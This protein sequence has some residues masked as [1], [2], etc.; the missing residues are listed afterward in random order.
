VSPEQAGLSLGV[1]TQQHAAGYDAVNDLRTLAETLATASKSVEITVPV[2]AKS[3]FSGKLIQVKHD[4]RITLITAFGTS[5]PYVEQAVQVVSMST[6][7]ATNRYARQMQ[8]PPLPKNW[9][10]ITATRASFP[11]S[12]VPVAQVGV[13]DGPSSTNALPG[14][15]AGEEALS[16]VELLGAIRHTRDACGQ[17]RMYLRQGHHSDDL[18]PEELYQLFQAIESGTE[19]L[20]VA[21][22]LAVGMTSATCVKVARAIAGTKDACKREVAELLLTAG[23]VPDKAENARLVQNELSAEQW[24]V[25]EKHLL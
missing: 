10:P 1:L 4:I 24:E 6:A 16:F 9:R 22:I 7:Q 21:E 23:P 14:K 17:L 15:A 25:V 3:S 12:D 18:Q 8:S 2:D 11:E 13:R 20:R 19:Q 5:N